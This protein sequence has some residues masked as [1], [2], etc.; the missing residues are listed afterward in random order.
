LTAKSVELDSE[1]SMLSERMGRQIADMENSV[2]TTMKDGDA[3][4]RLLNAI[5]LLS[6]S[7]Q[8]YN[9]KLREIK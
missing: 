4:T 7:H 1:T 8:E 5:K 6:Q 3:K 2:T 9:E